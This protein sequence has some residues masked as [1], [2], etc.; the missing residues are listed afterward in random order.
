M[1]LIAVPAAAASA[2]QPAGS[3]HGGEL[4]RAVAVH[5]SVGC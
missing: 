4:V 2:P 1:A 5:S 3:V